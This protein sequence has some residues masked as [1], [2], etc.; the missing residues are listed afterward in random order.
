MLS[1]VRAGM[2]RF[3][4]TDIVRFYWKHLGVLSLVGMALLALDAWL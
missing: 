4:V 2:A 1:L 3:R